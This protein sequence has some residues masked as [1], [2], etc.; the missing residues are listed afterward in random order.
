MKVLTK[1]EEEAHYN[2]T[3]KG[4]SI[5]GIIGTAVGAAGVMAASRRYHSFRALTVPFRAFLV[6]STGTFVGEFPHATL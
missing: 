4:G 5:G 2:A 1:E 3:V 6:A